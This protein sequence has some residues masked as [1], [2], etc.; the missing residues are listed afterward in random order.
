MNDAGA[1]VSFRQERPLQRPNQ[2]LSTHL[3][4]IQSK[5][6]IN[7]YH[8]NPPPR[9][10]ALPALKALARASRP[11]FSISTNSLVGVDS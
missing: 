11:W 4:R 10:D 6:L 7:T 1:P 9:L 3:Q 5:H 2:S 8:T